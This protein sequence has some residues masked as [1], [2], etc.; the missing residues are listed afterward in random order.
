MQAKD[1]LKQ[2]FDTVDKKA[3][4][5]ATDSAHGVSA[6]LKFKTF[7]MSTGKV[8]EYYEGLSSRV[9]KCTLPFVSFVSDD[10]LSPDALTVI[11]TSTNQLYIN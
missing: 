5:A 7:K 10:T 4:E 11:A 3:A 1:T 8:E 2:M 9:G 6:A